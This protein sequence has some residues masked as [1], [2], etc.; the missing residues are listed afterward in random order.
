MAVAIDEEYGPGHGVLGQI[1][2]WQKNF[3]G[4]VAEGERRVLLDPGDAEGAATL[5]MT[6]VFSGEPERA[7][8]S[9]ERAMRLDPQFPFWHLHVVG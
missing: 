6:L 8:E 5:A 4:A 7:L 9:I 3:D 1:Y 2:L